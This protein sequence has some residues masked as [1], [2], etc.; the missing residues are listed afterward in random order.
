MGTGNRVLDGGPDPP[1]EGAI[2]R[3]GKKR[4][5]VKYRDTLVICAKTAEPIEM[6][7]GLWAQMG[8]R[9]RVRWGPAVLRD[10]AMA[11]SFGMQFAI[12]GFLTFDGL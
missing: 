6:P 5:I 11:T 9:N 8:P 7:F 2:L 10:V 1:W 12:I 4:P 3:A